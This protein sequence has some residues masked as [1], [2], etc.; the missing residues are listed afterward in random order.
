MRADAKILTA[1]RGAAVRECPPMRAATLAFLVPFLPL[2]AQAEN[3]PTTDGARPAATASAVPIIGGTNAPAGKWPDVAAVYIDNTQECTGTLIAPNVVITAGHCNDPA[4]HI[5]KVLIGTSS[6]A[7]PSEGEII[8]VTQTFEYPNSQTSF[9]VTALVLAKNSTRAPRPIASGWASLDIKNGASVAIVGFGAIDNMA[10]VYVNELKEATTTITDAD[11]TLHPNDCQNAAKP[12]GELGAGGMGIDTC[13]GDS[14]GPLYTT[15]AGGT[16]L[17][18]VT[19]R[20]YVANQFQCSEGGLYV[21]PDKLLKWLTDTTGADIAHGPTP[22]VSD[23][24]TA[25]RGNPAD[26]T[27]DAN[28][29]ASDKHTYAITTPPKY[30]TA[31]IHDDG[32]LRVCTDPGVVVKDAIAISITDKNDATRTLSY[33]IPIDVTDG[34]PGTCDLTGGDSGGCCDARRSA[35]GSLPLGIGVLLLLR[36][37]RR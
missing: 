30:G 33:T 23:M 36:R 11:C 9:D 37:R 32:K 19:S 27:I 8:L 26:A 24:L 10:N 13:P 17:A 5:N 7:K 35:G 15:G 16:F 18:G 14:G 4:G 29:P 31:V 6:L 22:S 25:V 28:D 21:R 3:D 1:R 12:A 2:V 34:T 20:G